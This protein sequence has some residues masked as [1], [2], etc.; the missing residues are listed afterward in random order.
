[1]FTY[2]TNTSV[3]RALFSLLHKLSAMAPENDQKNST[4][5][6]RFVSSIPTEPFSLKSSLHDDIPVIVLMY[7]RTVHS[8]RILCRTLVANSYTLLR[9]EEN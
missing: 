7:T 6:K 3:P 5:S 8:S 4:A 1:M 2:F 9:K